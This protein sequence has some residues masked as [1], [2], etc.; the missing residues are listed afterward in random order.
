MWAGARQDG[1]CHKGGVREGAGMLAPVTKRSLGRA[2]VHPFTSH[3]HQ[4]VSATQL[5]VL[6]K[7]SYCKI[8]D[9]LPSHAFPAS[10]RSGSSWL[11]KL[12]VF[13]FVFFSNS[14]G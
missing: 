14:H 11:P 1:P 13:L 12:P 4:M 6:N 5:W 2:P 3:I 8:T 10:V 9:I 7:V